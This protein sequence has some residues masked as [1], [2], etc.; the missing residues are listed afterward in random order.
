M[1]VKIRHFVWKGPGPEVMRAIGQE[2]LD[3]VV[4]PRIAS[5]VNVNDAPAKPLST[6]GKRYQRYFYIK[7]AKGLNPV[8]D[9]RFTGA[10]MAAAKVVDATNNQVRIG[11]DNPDASRK[12]SFNQRRDPMFW[13]SPNDQAKIADIVKKHL[14]KVVM[15]GTEPAKSIP[16]ANSTLVRTA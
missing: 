10:M 9:L 2:V 13:W 14:T 3:T 1:S 12:A 5:A 11:F 15:I 4:R 8:R 16:A 7:K 6:K